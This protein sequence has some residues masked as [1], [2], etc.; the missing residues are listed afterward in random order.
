MGTRSNLRLGVVGVCLAMMIVAVP[1]AAHATGYECRMR[2]KYAQSGT[3]VPVIAYGSMA[4]I[5]YNQ[6]RLVSSSCGLRN[7]TAS[8]KYVQTYWTK[9][10]S[11]AMT[12]KTVFN[13][14]TT[15]F[16]TSFGSF[17]NDM[18]VRVWIE[19]VGPQKDHWKMTV[20]QYGVGTKST[21][22]YA[23]GITS[24]YV[25]VVGYRNSADAARFRW[26]DPFYRSADMY[27]NAGNSYRWQEAYSSYDNDPSKSLN[28]TMGTFYDANGNTY[29]AVSTIQN[30]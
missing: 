3:P 29:K 23:T 13:N 26:F 27:R 19:N 20:Y 21:D 28:R 9:S 8:G 11:T 22:W 24:S 7:T 15:T 12:Y 16:T 1:A 25:E 14:G 4:D 18:S 6:Q 10:N 30:F 17:R 2:L 5:D